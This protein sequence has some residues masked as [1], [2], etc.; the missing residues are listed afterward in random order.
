MVHCY[1][2]E[3]LYSGNGQN[4]NLFPYHHIFI[5]FLASDYRVQT[6]RDHA[7]KESMKYVI[8]IIR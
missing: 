6:I 3:L 1:E 5:S 2:T 7:V 8:S 4:S